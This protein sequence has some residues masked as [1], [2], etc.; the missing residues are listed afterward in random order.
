LISLKVLS[1]NVMKYTRIPVRH[2]TVFL[3]IYLIAK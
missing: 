3:S 2:D 1:R